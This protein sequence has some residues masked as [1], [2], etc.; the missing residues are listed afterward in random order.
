MHRV[1]VGERRW[2]GRSALSGRPELLRTPAGPEATQLPSTSAGCCSAMRDGPTGWRPVHF[3]RHLRRCCCCRRCI[4]RFGPLPAVAATLFPTA[5]PAAVL[6]VVVEAPRASAGGALRRRLQ[7]ALAAG[8]F[9]PLF[10]LH[11][12]FPWVVLAA[13]LI[14]AL[15]APR[16]A[17]GQYPLRRGRSRSRGP[18]H[19]AGQAGPPSPRRRPGSCARPCWPWCCGLRRCS[20]WPRGWR[21]DSLP[22][23]PG[24]VLQPGSCGELR[25]CLRG[26]GLRGAAGGWAAALARRSTDARWPGAGRNHAGPLNGAAVRRFLAA[27]QQ[28]RDCRRPPRPCWRRASR[29]G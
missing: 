20:R 14:G 5:P 15:A 16:A 29:C 19:R 21:P 22:R 23:S 1:L 27:W 12:G 7:W 26:A 28:P 9:P 10:V 6:A 24:P 8:A 13:G 17:V 11:I 4:A 18:T 3:C 2:I 25:R